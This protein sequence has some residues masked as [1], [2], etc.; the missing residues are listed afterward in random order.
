MAVVSFA[1]ESRNQGRVNVHH[2]GL[3][4]IRDADQ[5]KEAG[6]ADEIHASLT[7]QIENVLAEF[8]ARGIILRHDD[9]RGY[10][11]LLSSGESEGV[12]PAGDD[13]HNLRLQ[14]AVGD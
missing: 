2:P 5:L 7:A 14:P 3:E 4:V 6:E 10:L 11:G 13:E 12:N 9:G 1:A 8:F